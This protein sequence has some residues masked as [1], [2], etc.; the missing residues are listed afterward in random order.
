VNEIPEH[1]Q[2]EQHQKVHDISD[3]AKQKLLEMFD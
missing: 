2:E 3:I 1:K